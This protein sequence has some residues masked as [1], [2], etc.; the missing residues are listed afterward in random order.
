MKFTHQN[1]R[2]RKIKLVPTEERLTDAAG[3]GSMV[4]IF[5]SSSLSEPF[6]KCLPERTSNR[7]YGSYRLGLIQLSSFLYG[8]DSL[9]DLE[10][11]KQDPA[12][13]AIMRGETVVPRTMGNFL[14]DFTS[15]HLNEMNGYLAK[16]ALATRRH[17]SE[18]VEETFKPKTIH[19]SIDSTSH[20]Q[21]GEKMEGVTWNYKNEWCLDSQVIFDEL[22]LCYGFELR[23]GATKSGVRAPEMIERGLSG[24]KF[25]DEKIVSGD[26]AY[27]NQDCMR[28]CIKLGAK[29]TFTAND[30]TTEWKSHLDE[31]TKWETWEYSKE[32]IEKSIQRKKSL[33]IVELGRFYWQPS[34]AEG[35]RLPVVVKRTWITSEDNTLFDTGYWDYYGVVTNFSLLT[36][37][38]Q[39]VMKT[40]NRRGNAE[41]FIREEKYGYDLKHFPCLKLN[42]NYAFGLIA[43]VAHNILRWI[44]VIERPH[45]PHFSKKL[46]RRFIFIPGKVVR[47]ARQLIMKIPTRYYEE[48]RKLKEAWTLKPCASLGYG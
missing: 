22:G 47:H 18:V 38:I 4:E 28:T 35:L 24:F 11:F 33:P 34:W 1:W 23:S 46:R 19:L 43:M 14:R 48:V 41:N 7:S 29:F 12:L 10:E 5:E 30:A 13:E 6:R 3:L 31:I 44:A 26:A 39:E 21:H 25:K 2:P 37:S 40:H 9:D 36:H 45:K 8:H 17:I 32:E 27:C 42:A 16:Q 15:E 20:V